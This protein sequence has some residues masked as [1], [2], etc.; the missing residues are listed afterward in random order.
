MYR[1][2]LSKF[3]PIM[4]VMHVCICL[5]EILSKIQSKMKKICHNT[6]ANFNFF[7]HSGHD[8]SPKK[9]QF[10][11]NFVIVPYST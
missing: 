10:F 4:F 3:V 9:I 11:L 7:W 1:H 2:V 6:M 5:H 8:F